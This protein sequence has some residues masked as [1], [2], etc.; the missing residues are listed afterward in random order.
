QV[1]LENVT[2][3]FG[4]VPLLA[5][6]SLD[7]LGDFNISA[8]VPTVSLVSVEDTFNLKLPVAT[9]GS[10]GAN[11][12][13]TGPIAAPVLSGSFANLTP[14]RVDRVGFKT[15]SSQLS[16]AAAVATLDL[17]NLQVIP[18]AGGKITGAGSIGLGPKP[19]TGFNV[20]ATNIPGDAL[21]RLY[22][23]PAQVHLGPIAAQARVTGTVTN[24]QTVASWQLPQATYPTTGQ[25]TIITGKNS[26]LVRNALLSLAGG[27]IKATGQFAN[28]RFQATATI[29]H[30]YPGKLNNNIAFKTPLSGALNVSGHTTTPFK[31][32][33]IALQGSGHL[34]IAGGTVTASNIHAAGGHFQVSG[35]LA[36]I[37]PE[38]LAQ[39]P[40]ALRAPIS[41]TFNLSG[42]TAAFQ[43][44]KLALQ[45][46]AS[47]NVA[48]GTVTVSNL[49]TAGGQW[50]ASGVVSGLQVGQALPQ[51]PSQV[52]GKIGPLNA[53]YNL[54]GSL[55][56][57]NLNNVRGNAT[58]SLNVAGGTVRATNVQL[59]TGGQLQVAGTA[60]GIQLQRL[61]PQAPP[62]FQGTLSNGRFNLSG[63]LAALSLPNVRGNASGSLGVAGGTVTANNIQLGNGR[64]SGSVT[65]NQ[66]NLEPIAAVAL[67]S[68][69][70]KNGFFPDIRGL[71]NTDVN[72]SSPLSPLNLSGVSAFGQ[73][74]LQDLVAGG[75]AFDPVLA[76]NINLNPGKGA[77]LQIAGAKDRISLVLS[78][79][80]RPV[81]FL[82][83]LGS[84][85]AT[86]KTAGETLQ[87]TA[88]NFPISIF[89]AVAPLPPILASQ[90]VSGI[91]DANVG[92]NLNTYAADGQIA[93]ARPGI[94]T[95]IGD[96]F[97]AQFRYANGGGTLA[98][99]VLT[100]GPVTRYTLNGS[101]NQSPN[102]PQFQVAL[103]IAQAQIHTLLTSLQLYNIQDFKRGLTVPTYAKADAV[104][105]TP[106]GAPN[107]SL[108][109]Q[110]NI[111]SEI[112]IQQQQLLAK[113]K[114]SPLPPLSDFRGTI[115]G[116]LSAKGSLK[117]GV[118]AKF[119]LLGSNWQWGNYFFNPVIAKGSFSNGVLTILPFRLNSNLGQVAFVGQVGGPDQSGQL[120]VRNFPIGILNQFVKSLPISVAGLLNATATVAGSQHNPQAIGEI[121]LTGATLNQQPI[122]SATT[123]FSYNNA[124]L[125][126]DSSVVVANS[127]SP[128]Q[129]NGSIPY[130]LPS[131][132]KPNNDQIH[133]SVN[134]QN[135]GLGLLNVLT[136]QVAWE[137]G[138]GRLQVQGSGT[139]RRPLV[140]GTA[141]ISNAT[142]S[143]AMLPKQPLTNVNG[144]A[145]FNGDRIQVDG[146]QGQFKQ[147]TVAAQGAIPIF[148]QAST[149]APVANPL[150]VALN[151]L[152]VNLPDYYQGGVDGN[153]VITGSALQPV[154][155]GNVMLSK[156]QVLLT[157]ALTMAGAAAVS[158]SGNGAGGTTAKQL[159]KSKVSSVDVAAVGNPAT[160]KTAPAAASAPPVAFNNLQI[161]L[162][163]GV[164][165][166][167][168][169]IVNFQVAGDLTLNGSLSNL[170]PDGT[171][172][173]T[174]GD[175]NIFTTQFALARAAK[176]TITFNPNQGLIPDLNLRLVAVVPQVTQAPTTTY[177]NNASF[178][179]GQ[180]QSS[181]SSDLRA[182]NF[183][184][185]ET[186]RVQAHVT[187][188]ANNIF[189][190]L[191]LTSDPYRSR[192]EIISLLGGGFVQTLSNSNNSAL[193]AASFA[194]SALIG[195]FQQ[196]ISKFGN[197]VGLSSLR[198]FPTTITAANN[199]TST[200][201]LAAEGSIDIS[202]NLSGD[203]LRFLTPG[204]QPTQ[205]GL[206]YQLTNNVRV[207]TSTDFSGTN[208]AEVEY[209]KGF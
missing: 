136:N 122:N 79:T 75:L 31:P 91:L 44:Q 135:Q 27:T 208:N 8:R 61:L 114:A 130:A 15:I 147:G 96:Q 90:P 176:Q 168:P 64:V 170:R 71:L 38:T 51:L 82:F 1:G 17:K 28:N 121:D 98:N 29:D 105:T 164:S 177:D 13:V 184:S 78:P 109:S 190:N 144:T 77:S 18:T 131:G 116:E 46:D 55:T 178:L 54:F 188:P 196:P 133:L 32:E 195:N 153:V 69:F 138:Q 165:A 179:F 152:K 115:N 201:G 203:I 107:A 23:V 47:V 108:L 73:L 56:A 173:L 100:Q 95:F 67:A 94:G 120:R 113:A 110:L 39:V 126:F 25:A 5:S 143:A 124:R 118:A 207:R 7:T 62:Q 60:S 111:Y 193:G 34:N 185:L 171:I 209:Q 104:T 52:Q 72:F 68:R 59:A 22:G 141:T 19:G 53:R 76:G 26:L 49:Q 20:Q 103:N 180:P 197:A 145:R 80:Y 9:K 205:F 174:G 166:K 156:G 2:S 186:I 70:G 83:Q 85:I 191:V 162:G 200:F 21:A 139:L 160:K 48:G 132:V 150:T 142:I 88:S 202:G 163:K 99:G 154:L 57:L 125:N 89:K 123:S 204:N 11:L 37:K 12:R 65:A 102:G 24:L 187:G 92:L 43:P 50:Q 151:Q 119:N 97:T 106:V 157:K 175:L 30:L 194:S 158:S 140:T 127:H 93:I 63:N 206:S 10:F 129:I 189:N 183:G 192:G 199:R 74:R 84:A 128:I 58:G 40:P 148:A 45:G 42:S 149:N 87:V 66:V 137:G 81:S 134:V 36:G 161:A 155:G 181:Q 182:Q 169:P 16:F 33:A 159:E 41:G 86:G 3:S 167:L 112:K 172:R 6:G 117:T 14:V 101:L 146:I 35:N 4:K 198:I